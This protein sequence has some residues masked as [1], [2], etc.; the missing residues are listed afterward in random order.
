MPTM[1]EFKCN[2]CSKINTIT[3]KQYNRRLKRNPNSKLYCNIVCCNKDRI[4]GKP[5]TTLYDNA[6]RNCLTRN[7][8]IDIDTDY[9]KELWEKQDGKCALSGLP[10]SFPNSEHKDAF[11]ASIDRIDNDKGYI[12][13][14]VRITCLI[15]NLCRNGFSDEDV[16]KF[17]EAMCATH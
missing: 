6:R 9:I 12:K 2:Y 10:M 15:A 7:R 1:K 13:G 16:I 17:C 11:Q 4:K 5:F 8:E 3:L 14:N